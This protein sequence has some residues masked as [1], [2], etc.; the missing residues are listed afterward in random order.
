M[1]ILRVLLVCLGAGVLFPAASA[2]SIYV[3]PGLS[4]G[5]TYHLVFVTEGI[6]DGTSTA[7][8]DYNDFVNAQAARSGSLTETFGIDWFAI[9]STATVNARDNAVVSAAVYLLNGTK[10][11][12]GFADLWDG[13]LIAPGINYD[14]F[15]G[16][17]AVENY[18]IWT[19]SKT[20]GSTDAT[21]P[22]GGLASD[23]AETG[24]VPSAAP[25]WIAAGVRPRIERLP[26]YALSELLTVPTSPSAVPEAGSLLV[27]L[28]LGL[29]ALVR[30]SRQ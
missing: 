29:A 17:P 11:A 5:D 7:I 24:V 2:G 28:V 10:I 3:P 6:R 15:G 1:S 21:Y 27:W 23:H 12:N 16:T 19:G 14:Q 20:D 22:L 26:F 4:S 13:T 18:Y 9:A 8:G 30:Q 25:S